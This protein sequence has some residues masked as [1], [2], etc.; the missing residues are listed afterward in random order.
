MPQLGSDTL[1]GSIS[2]PLF[3]IR[4]PIPSTD[5]ISAPARPVFLPEAN[6]AILSPLHFARYLP[7]TALRDVHATPGADTS[8]KV[9]PISGT[10]GGAPTHLQL[11]ISA[12][13]LDGSEQA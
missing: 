12:R 9:L 6:D 7:A 8:L 3:Q 2:L 4:S 10:S 13:A 1:A 5:T 11:L